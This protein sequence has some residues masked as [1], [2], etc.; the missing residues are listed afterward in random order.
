M[1]TIAMPMTAISPAAIPIAPERSEARPVPKAQMSPAM[2]PMCPTRR[3][4][5]T[6]LARPE[7]TS[8]ASSDADQERHEL[9]E[10]SPAASG[11]EQAQDDQCQPSRTR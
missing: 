6:S 8:S 1:P 9:G 5:S 10:P 2:M 7:R 11:P 4:Q 3:T